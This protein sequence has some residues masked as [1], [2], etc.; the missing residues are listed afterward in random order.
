MSVAIPPRV[1]GLAGLS[2][3]LKPNKHSDYGDLSVVVAM[4]G[5]T[6]GASSLMIP[7][8]SILLIGLLFSVAFTSPLLAALS[9]IPVVEII[10]VNLPKVKIRISNPSKTVQCIIWEQGMSWEEQNKWFSLRSSAGGKIW[11]MHPKPRDYTRN[12]PAPQRI[13]AGDSLVFKY[14]FSDES[15][16]LPSG[17][18]PG[19]WKFDIQA[20]LQIPR[21]VDAHR[22][23]V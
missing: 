8:K 9:P 11:E 6:F 20:H 2:S 23:G 12:F 22:F 21:D 16:A 14:D 4:N 13:P 3:I 7:M 1:R 15:W 5:R 18:A 10:S 19:N 17:F